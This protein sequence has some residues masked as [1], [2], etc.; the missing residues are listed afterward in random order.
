MCHSRSG[1]NKI[2][3]LPQRC[4]WIVYNDKKSSFK[5]LLGTD[6]SVPIHIKNQ[7]VLATEMFKVYRNT[8]PPIVR[9]LL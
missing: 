5:E 3:K 9:Q 6:K 7:Q 1:N 4:L 8:Y 2:N